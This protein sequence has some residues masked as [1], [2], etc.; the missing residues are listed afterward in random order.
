[1]KSEEDF[2]NRLVILSGSQTKTLQNRHWIGILETKEQGEVQVELGG[3]GQ[4]Q[5]WKDMDR[6]EETSTR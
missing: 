5:N 2:E 4:H 6:G 3:K 1:M